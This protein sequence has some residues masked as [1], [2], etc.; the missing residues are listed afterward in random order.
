MF[1]VSVY[2]KSRP[3]IDDPPISVS[4]AST[5]SVNDGE[6]NL[7]RMPSDS[8][9]L[10]PLPPLEDDCD[11]SRFS[12]METED[13]LNG[14]VCDDMGDDALLSEEA[15]VEMDEQIQKSISTRKSQY[16]R[17]YKEA[18]GWT[19]ATCALMSCLFSRRQMAQSTVL[20][21]G[22]QPSSSGTEA[23]CRLPIK[24]VHYIVGKLC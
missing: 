8:I 6:E 23:R 2:A 4:G 16:W 10:L 19:K 11:E 21:R 14:V 18:D 7:N 20:G 5:V 3:I 17:L 24:S 13:I 1:L 12:D 22:G 9:P 15:L